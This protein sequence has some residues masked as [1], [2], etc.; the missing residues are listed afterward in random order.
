MISSA[1]RH[2]ANVKTPLNMPTKRT[3]ARKAKAIKATTKMIE[4]IQ[5]FARPIRPLKLV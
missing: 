4:A 1:L 2:T 3:M 5:Y